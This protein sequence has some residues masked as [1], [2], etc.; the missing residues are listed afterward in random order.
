[1]GK[2]YQTATEAF[3]AAQLRC[4]TTGA[5]NDCALAVCAVWSIRHGAHL[6]LQQYEVVERICRRR[7]PSNLYA[8]V[9]NSLIGCI[10]RI[11]KNIVIVLQISHENNNDFEKQSQIHTLSNNCCGS[12]LS[13]F[14]YFKSA[15][16]SCTLLWEKLTVC[17]LVLDL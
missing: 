7:F 9:C 13:I 17:Y 6:H 5:R 4:C 2:T 3:D 16:L 12:L 10:S 11:V 1:M 15:N 14:Q 8:M